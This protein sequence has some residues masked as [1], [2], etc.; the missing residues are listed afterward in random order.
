LFCS[1][2]L[3]KSREVVRVRKLFSRIAVRDLGYPGAKVA[4]Y[5]GVTTSA[6]NKAASGEAP[7]QVERYL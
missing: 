2:V 3:G 1:V 4:R 5:L 6:V 7:P